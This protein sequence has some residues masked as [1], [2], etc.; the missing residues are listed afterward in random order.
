M[1]LFYANAREL[2]IKRRAAR[3]ASGW[4]MLGADIL[5]A[6]WPLYYGQVPRVW[7]VC[8]TLGHLPDQLP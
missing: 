2:I 1:M 7:V 6:G 3:D 4:S 8:L 5:V